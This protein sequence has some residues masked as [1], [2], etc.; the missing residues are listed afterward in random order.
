MN[1]LSNRTHFEISLCYSPPNTNPFRD[2]FCY[3]PL[4]TASHC[5]HPKVISRNMVHVYIVRP[6]WEDPKK[7]L[8]NFAVLHLIVMQLALIDWP[9]KCAYYTKRYCHTTLRNSS[10]KTLL[11]IK[12][13]PSCCICSKGHYYSESTKMK[14]TARA[15]FGAATHHRIVTGPDAHNRGVHARNMGSYA[16]NTFVHA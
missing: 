9:W 15:V 6:H 12:G 5:R 2:S 1:W 13:L 11:T 4:N 3:S 10:N 8:N 14:G 16:C 7:N